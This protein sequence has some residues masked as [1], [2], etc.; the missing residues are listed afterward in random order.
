[1]PHLIIEFPADRLAAGQI[2]SLL[3]AVHRGAVGTGLFDESHIRIRAIPLEH[4]RLG[5]ERAPFVHVQCRI[6]AGRDEAQRQ[7]LSEAVLAAVRAEGLPLKVI[8]VEV[9]TLSRSDYAKYSAQ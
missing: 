8:T 2:E 9:V 4:Y 1:V 7:S 6:H 5:G 3:D